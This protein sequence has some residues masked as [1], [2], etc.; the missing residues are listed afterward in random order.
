MTIRFDDVN[1]VDE[2]HK[3]IIE[4]PVLVWVE[5]WDQCDRP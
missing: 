3:R 2:Q 1:H 4:A 5:V